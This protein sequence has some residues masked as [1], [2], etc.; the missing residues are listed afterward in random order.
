[1][2][3]SLVLAALLLAPGPAQ[4]GRADTLSF[5]TPRRL[6]ALDKIKGEPI[7]LAWSP[8]GGELYVQAGDRTRIG[9]FE[10]HRHYVI[11]QADQKVKTV[12]A[13]PSWAADYFA[14][15]AGRAAPA[16]P[17]FRIDIS[18]DK[19]TQRAISAPMGGDLAKGGGNP[20]ASGASSDDM[21]TAALTS[22]IQHVITLKL[23]GEVVGEYVDLQFVPG[24]TF[25]W[26]PASVGVVI[27]YGGKDGHLSVMDKDG[28]KT[29]VPDTKNVLLPAWSDKGTS[30]AFVQRN[31]KK[32]DLFVTDVK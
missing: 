25:G 30:I 29:Q 16:A 20:G 15:K 6:L 5:S 27:A 31:G 10:N 19:R 28:G 32:F 23:K 18:E 11:S 24:Y 12:D 7:Q 21:V 9:T 4:Q 13:P 3:T 8:D 14:W 22:Q 26:A 17:A 1:M 2:V